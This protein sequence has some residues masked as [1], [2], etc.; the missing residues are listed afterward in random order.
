M[1][2][3]SG[4]GVRTMSYLLHPPLLDEIGLAAALME[5]V[6]GLARRS[7]MK[8]ALD[9]AEDLERLDRRSE[10]ALFRVAQEGV[11]LAHRRGSTAPVRVRVFEERDWVVVEVTDEG[12]GREGSR[13]VAN[14]LTEE[15]EGMV[16]LGMR[17]RVRQLGGDLDLERQAG[18]FTVRAR[19]PETAATEAGGVT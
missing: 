16:I 10:M 6:D 14:P 18:R 4:R 11:A 1:V 12:V 3:Q 2:E 17:E 8:V 15:E 5:F 19:V 9:C 13:K 7:G